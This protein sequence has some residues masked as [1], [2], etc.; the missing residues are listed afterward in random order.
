MFPWS[1][2]LRGDQLSRLKSLI[3]RAC[4]NVVHN[5]EWSTLDWNKRRRLLSWC[6]S[7]KHS[8]L[9]FSLQ[10][11]FFGQC[12]ILLSVL[13]LLRDLRCPMPYLPLS[14]LFDRTMAPFLLLRWIDILLNGW[15]G[16]TWVSLDKRIDD[17]K[18]ESFLLIDA[19]SSMPLTFM[20]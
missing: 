20:V 14:K 18:G 11:F 2:N 16:F 17:T 12:D 15:A 8:A 6:R 7:C 13:L 19:W 10:R 9:P 3:V 5:G 1:I 4:V